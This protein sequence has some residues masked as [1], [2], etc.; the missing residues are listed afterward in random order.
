MFFGERAET[1]D[2]VA[3]PE[4]GGSHRPTLATV[5]S[6]RPWLIRPCTACKPHAADETP[7]YGFLPALWAVRPARY[8][9]A[10]A[11]DEVAPM[12]PPPEQAS[13]GSK[14]LD[15]CN[16]TIRSVRAKANWNENLARWGTGLIVVLTAS[17][18]VLLIASTHWDGFVVGKFVPAILTAAAAALAGYLQFEK[19]HERWKLYRGYQ[20]ALEVER[21]RFENKAPPYDEA[22]AETKLTERL[23]ELQLALHADWAGLL[24]RSSEVA[25]RGPGSR[26]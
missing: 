6:P 19:P 1:L 22:D 20:R 13:S 23:A 16:Q 5:N 21:M 14:P 17:V 4:L 2:R 25:A 15:A 9:L 18:S 12:N 11:H 7:D 3:I 8:G 10:D 24:P 26:L